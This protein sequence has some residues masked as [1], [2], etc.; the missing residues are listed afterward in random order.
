MRATLARV[1]RFYGGHPLH[2][3]TLL[4]CFAL[5]GYAVAKTAVSPQW[6]AMLVWFLA[7]V[8]GHDLVLFPIYALADRSL[9]TVLHALR[10]SP[11]TRPPVPAVNHIRIPTLAAALLFLMFFPGIIRQGGDTYAAATGQD[12]EPFLERWLLLTAAFFAVSAGVYALRL[13]RHRRR[14]TGKRVRRHEG[15]G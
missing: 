11:R 3:L 12:Q 8:V 6:P 9:T 7:A 14:T 10:R 1:K 13:W 15:E 4:A 2:V 5:A